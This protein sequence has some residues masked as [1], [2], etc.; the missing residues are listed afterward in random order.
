MIHRLFFSTANTFSFFVWWERKR[1]GG[2]ELLS[3]LPDNPFII[4]FEYEEKETSNDTESDNYDD[5]QPPWYDPK[6]QGSLVFYFLILAG[7]EC[8]FGGVSS[9]S[10]I[11]FLIA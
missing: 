7:Y 9:K 2:F 5:Q 3:R 10:E 6:G 1:S 8:E 11:T 4:T